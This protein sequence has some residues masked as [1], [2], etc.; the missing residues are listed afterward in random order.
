MPLAILGLGAAELLILLVMLPLLGALFG[1]WIW[2]LIDCATKEDDQTQKIVWII[3]IALVGIIGAPLCF[4]VRELPRKAKS[5]IKTENPSLK[6]T[7][8]HF[9]IVMR[10]PRASC[11]HV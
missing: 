5:D 8:T 3:L 7:P 1:F 6:T 2:M 9:R 4:F 11:G 10:T